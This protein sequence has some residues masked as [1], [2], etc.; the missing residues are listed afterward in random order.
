MTVCIATEGRHIVERS[1]LRNS[2]PCGLSSKQP[3]QIIT[4]SSSRETLLPLK[5]E[6]KV[7][8]SVSLTLVSYMLLENPSLV[9]QIGWSQA[10]PCM[11]ISRTKARLE[12]EYSR[13]W[14]KT[15]KEEESAVMGGIVKA[16]PN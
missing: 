3:K 15:H 2:I 10:A 12:R 9:K 4:I 16:H 5:I 11:P 13:H 7:S 6:A 1:K 8:K 14:I